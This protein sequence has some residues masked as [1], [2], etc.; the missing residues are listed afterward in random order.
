MSLYEYRARVSRV[1]DGDTVDLDIDLGLRVTSRQRCRLFGLNA[2]EVRGSEREAGLLA[3][4]WLLT[5][6]KEVEDEDGLI[7]ISTHKDKRG[8]YG[9]Y[10]VTLFDESGAPINAQMIDAGHAIVANY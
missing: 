2:P 4:D 8:K 1:V 6:L 5:R 9:R 3:T 10:L 7:T